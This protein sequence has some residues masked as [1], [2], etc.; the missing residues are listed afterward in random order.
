MIKE[1]MS[2]DS[3]KYTFGLVLTRLSYTRFYFFHDSLKNL[4]CLYPTDLDVLD[5]FVLNYP[6]GSR[7]SKFLILP[8]ANVPA[9]QER[10]CTDMLEVMFSLN[11]DSF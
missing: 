5:C 2:H 4:V 1:N 9:D 8:C 11:C 6:S 3:R 10:Y 7:I